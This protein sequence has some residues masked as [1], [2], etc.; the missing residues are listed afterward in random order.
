MVSIITEP[1]CGNG[2]PLGLNSPFSM[3]F[4][5]AEAGRELL[6]IVVSTTDVARNKEATMM[7]IFVRNGAAPFPP[8]NVV[9]PPPNIPER[10]PLLEG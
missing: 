9:P 7:V 10:P 8:K 4:S 6:A 2:Q 3:A 5:I 1:P